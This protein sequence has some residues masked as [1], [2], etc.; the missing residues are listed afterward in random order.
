MAFAAYMWEQFTL[1]QELEFFARILAACFCGALIGVERSRRLKEAG[2]RTHVIVCCAAA[3]VMIVSKY[4]FAD[5][6]TPEGTNFPGVRG[7][8][9]ARIAAQV[10]SGVSFLGAGVIFKHGNTIKG[11][12]TAAGIWAT[13]VIGLAI[14]AGMYLLGAFSTGVLILMQFIMHHLPFGADSQYFHVVFTV[15]DDAAF[16]AAF[17]DYVHKTKLKILKNDVILGEDGGCDYTLVMHIPHNVPISDAE[18]FF[19]SVCDVHSMHYS[20]IT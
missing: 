9:S 7:A 20:S 18:K 15:D 4:G 19:R 17:M 13:A 16:R 10:V 12:T 11:L 14:G 5:L 3:L 8:D 2:I 6:V 1:V